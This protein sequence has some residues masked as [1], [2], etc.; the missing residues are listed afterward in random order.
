MLYGSVTR[1]TQRYLKHAVLANLKGLNKTQIFPEP[2][3][4]GK[5]SATARNESESESEVS[6]HS[7]SESYLT[8]DSGVSDDDGVSSPP[9][10]NSSGL[11]SSPS[12][13]KRSRSSSDGEFSDALERF[14]AP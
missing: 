5:E 11:G 14:I 8:C 12:S 10:E 1:R 3:F 9:S 6:E 2:I 4:E 7:E 13:R